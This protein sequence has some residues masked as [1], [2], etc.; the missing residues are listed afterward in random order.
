VSWQIAKT[1]KLPKF[2]GSKLFNF[3]GYGN[4]GN[5][6]NARVRSGGG[7]GDPDQLR[8]GSGD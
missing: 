2:K 6:G 4:F 7:F 8:S 5:F 1:A 3:G